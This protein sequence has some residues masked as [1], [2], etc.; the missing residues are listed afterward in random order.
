M[1]TKFATRFAMAMLAL[2]MMFGAALPAAA[3][4]STVSTAKIFLVA[5][6][7][8]APQ[9]QL[10]GCGDQLIPVQVNIQSTSSTQDKI[11]EALQALFG[12]KDRF[13]GQSGLYDALYQAN[14]T[15]DAV[16]VL[17]DGAVTVELSGSLNIGGV[18]D[19]PRVKG[20]IEQTVL[21]FPDVTGVVV[22]LNGQPLLPGGNTQ[23]FPETGHTVSG[24]FL[25][26]WQNNGGLP[27]FGY[28]LSDV[29]VENGR[30]V[31][32]FERQ[33]F[34]YH[35]ENQ[36]PFNILL[37]LLGTQK[38][39]NLGL[40]GT[41][42]FKA[43]PANSPNRDQC[44]FFAETGHYVCYGFRHYWETH[45][46][47]FGDPGVSYRESLMLFGYP[48]SDEFTD[49]QSGMTVQYFQRAV[50]EYHPNNPA[51]WRILLARLGAEVYHP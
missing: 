51:D 5:L 45:G 1:P 7:A 28:P 36:A 15:V 21:Q 17:S 38:A 22:L 23:T 16:H 11:T 19:E 6:N 29:V 2:A 43:L 48:I 13:Y 4:S 34:E 32:Y 9:D 10:I 26:F 47:N 24:Q 37:G 42:P 27:V 33:R 18:C 20:Q 35:P 25:T 49:P 30:A 8:S 39:S 41:Q 46:L 50:F 3:V 12:I 44:I 40:L 14:L 31:Q